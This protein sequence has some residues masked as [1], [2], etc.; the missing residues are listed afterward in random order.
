MPHL[1]SHMAKQVVNPAHPLNSQV[2]AYRA[3]AEVA[4]RIGQGAQVQGGVTINASQVMVLVQEARKA[5]DAAPSPREAQALEAGA[6]GTP[7]VA[8]EAGG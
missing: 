6:P 8:S 7:G 5:R 2:G 1:T 3:V 4:G